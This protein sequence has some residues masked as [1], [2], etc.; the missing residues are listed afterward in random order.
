M[1]GSKI[2]EERVSKYNGR[3]RVQKTLFM[4]TYIQCEGLTQSGGIVES[5]WKQTIRE[6]QITRGSELQNILI[7]GLGGG[8]VAKIL[9]K[10]YAGAKIVGVE[11]DPLMIE[12]G[13]KYLGLD[14][15]NVDIRIEDALTSNLINDSWDLVIVD[16]YNGDN[17]PKQFE[18]INFLNSLKKNKVVIFNRLF[19]GEKKKESLKFGEKLKKVYKKVEIYRPVA[20]IMYIC[21]K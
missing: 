4:G 5:I 10:K 15:Y 19:F 1:L 17:F 20:N 6:F 18:N 21:C 12:M 13:K 16:L 9:R 7:L 11:I 2:L 14:K 3:L 8:T